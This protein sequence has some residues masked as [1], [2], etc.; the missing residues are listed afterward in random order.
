M[1]DGRRIEG[2]YERTN[3]PIHG[4]FSLS[5]ASY[6]VMPRTLLQSMPVE[7]QERFVKCLNEYNAAFRSVEQADAYE[8]RVLA[9]ER[10]FIGYTDSCPDCAGDG[11]ALTAYGQ[12]LYDLSHDGDAVR[13]P[14]Q[15]EVAAFEEQWPAE[16]ALDEECPCETCDGDGRI[17]RDHPYETAEEVG[18]RSDPVPHYDRGRT[19]IAP[20]EG[21]HDA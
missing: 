4:W 19:Y 9:R 10:Q 16:L 7:W 17:D 20:E 18:F 12:A 6:L 13:E 15:A 5:Y 14:T 2:A 11:V 8:V 1:A 21:R 3:G